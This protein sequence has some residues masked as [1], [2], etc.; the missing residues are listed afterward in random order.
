M[1]TTFKPQ[2][3]LERPLTVEDY[4]TFP[5]D[6]NRYEIIGGQLY[7]SPSP[8]VEHQ[9]IVG[10]LF[11]A[12]GQFL[13]EHGTGEA[14][15]A[16]LDVQFSEFD[17]VQPDIVAVLN[18][19]SQIKTPARVVGAPDLVVEVISPSSGVRDRVDKAALYVR[20]GV[21]EY[22]LVDPKTR[23][24]I[25]QRWEH[26]QLV[27]NEHSAGLVRSDL[28]DGFEVDLARLFRRPPGEDA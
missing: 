22:W 10:R 3:T 6:G 27:R 17:V 19:N 5:D 2:Q 25:I 23:M 1:A 20:N 18:Q 26:G 15:T 28:L 7:V 16:P 12:I 8:S 4:E 9:R 24:L 14:F 13:E 21:R 11:L